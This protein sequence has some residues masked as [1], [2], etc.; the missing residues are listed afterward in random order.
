VGFRGAERGAGR[1]ARSEAGGPQVAPPARRS[2]RSTV[3]TDAGG[4]S[5]EK[6]KLIQH[7]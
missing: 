4:E 2:A 1:E 6:N 5:G 7:Y 3:L